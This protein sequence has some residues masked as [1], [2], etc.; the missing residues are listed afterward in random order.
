MTYAS[1]GRVEQG[2]NH[3][4]CL[5]GRC[6]EQVFLLQSLVQLRDF[7]LGGHLRLRQE[8]ND[9]KPAHLSLPL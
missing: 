3:V 4:T 1:G 5:R 6:S 7:R 2:D 9:I 8:S